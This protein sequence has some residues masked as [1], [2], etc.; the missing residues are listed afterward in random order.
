M[1]LGKWELNELA[2][3]VA[4]GG[5]WRPGSKCLSMK[6]PAVLKE[7]GHKHITSLPPTPDAKDFHSSTARKKGK[8]TFC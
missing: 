8:L 1:K 5:P 4:K 3:E 6:A 7:R 2:P